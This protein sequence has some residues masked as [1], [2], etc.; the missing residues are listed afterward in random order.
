MEGA[1]FVPQQI[2][3][4]AAMLAWT[5]G[6][7]AVT[8]EALAEREDVSAK[9]ASGRLDEAVRL[10]LLDRESLLVGYSSLY[11][12]TPKG[13]RL[14]RKYQ[15]AGEYVYPERLRTSRVSIKDARHMIACAGVTAALER[16]YPGHR[17][18]GEIELH[19]DE[20]EGGR[21][22][23][24]VEIAGAGRRRSHF[25]DIVIW[26]PGTLDDPDT[27]ASPTSASAPPALP[28]AIEVELTSKSKEEL[29]E[30]L[31]AWARCR[32]IEAVLYFAETRKIEQK[33]LD[34]VEELKAEEE[35]VVNPLSEILKPQP[36]FPLLDE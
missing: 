9:I 18:I 8:P 3:A 20:R 36:G 33:L 1:T 22:L 10:G 12:V 34:V 24:S 7:G 21:R 5:A 32:T 30:N 6:L 31:R 23:A 19:R 2:L 13:R 14:A 16:R 27:P 17:V 15:D 29:V 25:P 35:I 4:Q 28:I 11:T 26:P